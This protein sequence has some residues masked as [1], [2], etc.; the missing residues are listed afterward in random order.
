MIN[1]NFKV[2]DYINTNI[3]GCGYII[4]ILKSETSERVAICVEFAYNF[5]NPREF[6]IISI[7]PDRT[8]GVEGWEVVGKLE[9]DTQ[10]ANRATSFSHK[11]FERA[12]Q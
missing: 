12:T 9:F 2:G 8:A 11:V 6:G 10:L 7:T 4:D 3:S 5:P 1:L